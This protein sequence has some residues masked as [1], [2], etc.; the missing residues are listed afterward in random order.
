MEGPLR[1]FFFYF[2][3]RELF[4]NC[5]TTFRL[6]SLFAGWPTLRGDSSALVEVCDLRVCISTTNL[7]LNDILYKTVKAG[8]MDLPPSNLYYLQFY[9]FSMVFSSTAFIKF[10]DSVCG[11]I[12]VCIYNLLQSS[13]EI[14]TTCLSACLWVHMTS[15]LARLITPISA[16]LGSVSSW[17]PQQRNSWLGI[18]SLSLTN[19]R[20]HQLLALLHW[21]E[22]KRQLCMFF[23]KM[24]FLHEQRKTTWEYKWSLSVTVRHMVQRQKPEAQYQQNQSVCG[25]LQHFKYGCWCQEALSTETWIPSPHMF[26][27]VAQKIF[28]NF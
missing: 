14:F 4:L 18:L 5:H 2:Y 3:F 7:G 20:C 12:C 17:I 21:R 1:N 25:G 16:A 24:P 28:E 8:K 15:C 23:Q 19:Y 26:N 11:N 6:G 9:L 13:C 10:C 22:I 27:P